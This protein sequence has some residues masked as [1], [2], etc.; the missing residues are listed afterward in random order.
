[1]LLK[2]PR[3]YEDPFTPDFWDVSKAAQWEYW[4]VGKPT[5]AGDP[6]FP[7]GQSIGNREGGGR[8]VP[9]SARV[10]PEG[11]VPAGGAAGDCG[12]SGGG[13]GGNKEILKTGDATGAGDNSKI[14]PENKN[15]QISE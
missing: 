15:C 3:Y 9:V 5:P 1:M 11:G 6:E 13:G 4:P 12:G 8:G 7:W 10:H 14:D 2:T